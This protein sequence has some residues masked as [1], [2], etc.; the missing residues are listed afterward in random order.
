MK[1]KMKRRVDSGVS[2]VNILFQIK[3]FVKKRRIANALNKFI[4]RI[5]LI[6]AHRSRFPFEIRSLTSHRWIVGRKACVNLRLS[7][8]QEL[9]RAE[10]R[11]GTPMLPACSIRHGMRVAILN[12]ARALRS[13]RKTARATPAPACVRPRPRAHS[14]RKAQRPRRRP[15][16]CGY[17]HSR[18]G[19]RACSRSRRS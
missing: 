9:P 1:K 13:D 19:A 5:D 2:N 15:R 8:I 6:P 12:R 10:S 18:R 4:I 7:T 17:S 14:S 16:P 3:L 11:P